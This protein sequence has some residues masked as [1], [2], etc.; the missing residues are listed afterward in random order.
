MNAFINRRCA[1]ALRVRPGDR[2]LDVGAGLG[3]FAREL[4]G[5][6]GR[7]GRVLGVE[8]SPEQIAAGLERARAEG[9]ADLVELRRGDARELPLAEAEWGSFDVVHARFLLEHVADPL[10]VVRQMC[11]A[12]RPGGRVVLADD[13]HE[14]MRLE[15]EPEG[16]PELWRAY[17]ASYAAA[18]LDPGIG[19]RLV[20]LLAGAGAEPRQNDLV[21]FGSCSGSPELEACVLNLVR[22][23][24]GGR[25]SVLATGQIEPARFDAAL[26]RLA[27]L[28]HHAGAAVWY[29]ICWA[30][31]VRPG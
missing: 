12:A 9:E 16:F 10:A 21:F 15:P 23:V 25:E 26:E 30:E 29:A 27:A 4:A 22:V 20:S 13:D 19:R 11:R 7:E 31:G 28:R 17:Q 6:V 5:S 1:A 8:R 18:G 24:E 2:V 14:G 3:L